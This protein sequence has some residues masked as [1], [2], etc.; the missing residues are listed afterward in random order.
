[1]SKLCLYDYRGGNNQM[2]RYACVPV[3]QSIQASIG[4]ATNKKHTAVN[5]NCQ[6]V[7]RVTLSHSFGWMYGYGE[8]V[9]ISFRV[10]SRLANN[11]RTL[12]TTQAWL[13]GWLNSLTSHATNTTPSLSWSG[14]TIRLF[15]NINIFIL[16]SIL[17]RKQ[18]TTQKIKRLVKTV[19][20]RRKQ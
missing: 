9:C 6:N 19:W 10:I 2:C 12:Y 15:D 7:Y 13:T 11:R 5:K 14:L 16:K 1:M 3:H 20:L 18:I 17:E 8:S 4:F